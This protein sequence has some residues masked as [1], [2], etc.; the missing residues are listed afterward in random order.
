MNNVNALI[1]QLLASQ[2]TLDRMEISSRII[3]T[4]QA[5]D[6]D[7][8]ATEKIIR[9]HFILHIKAYAVSQN[10]RQKALINRL[11]KFYDKNYVVKTVKNNAA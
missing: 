5:S 7:F 2:N 9:S 1:S 8:G 11:V 6:F 3:K 4:L 10:R